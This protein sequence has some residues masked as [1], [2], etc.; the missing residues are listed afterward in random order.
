M[1]S[2]AIVIS[3]CFGVACTVTEHTCHTKLTKPNLLVSLGCCCHRLKPG[4]WGKGGEGGGREVSELILGVSRI[5]PKLSLSV[6]LTVC[7]SVT[8]QSTPPWLYAGGRG[9]S[10]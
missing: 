10:A 2:Y 3:P 8:R 4:E 6:V 1:S 9:A 7:M 5:D